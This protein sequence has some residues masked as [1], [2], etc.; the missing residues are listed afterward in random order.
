MSAIGRIFIVLNL[1]LAAA[2]LGWASQAK[3]SIEDYK[4]KFDDEKAARAEEAKAADA[5]SSKLRIEVSD[6]KDEARTAN[7]AR[8]TA[9]ALS[10]NLQGQ[11]DDAQS[12]NAGLQGR[13]DEIAATL[14]DYNDTISQLVQEKDNA[15]QRAN[16]A[17]RARDDA[18]EAAQGAEMARR[19]ADEAQNAANTQIAALTEANGALQDEVSSL[20]T[21]IQTIVAVTG[22]DVT[23]IAAVAPIDAAVLEARYDIEPGLVMLNVGNEAGVKRGYTFHVYRGGQYKG[24]VRVE[25]VQANYCSA[26]IIGTQEGRTISQGDSASTVL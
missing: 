11:N 6:L 21:Q 16:D 9:V 25:N 3:G 12:K 14:G 26:V 7:G 19:D 10:T 22:I 23:Q 13:L 18:N 5:A 1:I 17:E 2:F 8:D 20:N 15:V 24:Q 4:T